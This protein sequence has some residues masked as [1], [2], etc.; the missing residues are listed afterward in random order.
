ML[1]NP[2]SP[3]D[4]AARVIY[5]SLFRMTKLRSIDVEAEGPDQSR[6]WSTSISDVPG[7]LENYI[8]IHSGSNTHV[9]LLA[10]ARTVLRQLIKVIKKVEILY[11]TALINHFIYYTNFTANRLPVTM[12]RWRTELI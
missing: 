3:I 2:M 11:Q 9:P 7:T 12:S 8:S 1:M 5:W 10:V 4:R 6:I